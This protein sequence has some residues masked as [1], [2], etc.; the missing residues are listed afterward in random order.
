M[1]GCDNLCDYKG[2]D[3]LPTEC[4]APRAILNPLPLPYID[5]D[6]NKKIIRIYIFM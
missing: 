4:P 5:K 3:P 6:C 2:I 1:T